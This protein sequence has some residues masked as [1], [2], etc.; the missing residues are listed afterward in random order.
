MP[1]S[2]VCKTGL[3]EQLCGA[4]GLGG[5]GLPLP[6]WLLHKWNPIERRLLGHTSL[7]WAGR[8]LRSFE[9]MAHYIA[10]TTTRTGLIVTAA[11][12]RG[13]NELGERVTDKEIQRLKLIPHRVCP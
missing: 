13:G 12:R 11:L 6:H 5:D 4:C 1:R 7:N 10:H 8:P 9:L 3:Q 2:R